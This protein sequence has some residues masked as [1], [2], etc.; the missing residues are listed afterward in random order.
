MMV[1]FKQLKY[2]G[3][4]LL[5]SRLESSKFK[6]IQQNLEKIKL[7]WEKTNETYSVAHLEIL[8]VKVFG[9]KTSKE[10]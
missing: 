6:E 8:P 4:I 9:V 3:Q 2:R 5:S 1:K 10:R 7:F